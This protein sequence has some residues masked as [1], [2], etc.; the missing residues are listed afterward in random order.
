MP[1]LFVGH[2]SP[3]NAIEENE[4]SRG[5]R[6][7]AL[8]IPRPRAVLCVSAHWETPGLR[9]TAN[10][11]PD[12]IHDFQGFPERLFQARYPAPGS[13]GLAAR[14]AAL[15]SG[16]GARLD[17]RRGL[18]H[19]SWSVLSVMYPAADIPV[20]QLSLDSGRTVSSHLAT[21]RKLAP[22]RD[23]GVLV[24]GSGDIVHNLALIDFDRADG[25]DW[26]DRFNGAVKDRILAGDA[27]A[28]RD[29]RAIDRDADLAVPTPEHYLPLLYILALREKD[30]PLSCFNDKV[31]MGSI[32]MTSFGVGTAP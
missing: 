4:F 16:E 1:A 6:E 32:S 15:L 2:G 7:A 19:G 26:A 27:A 12:T 13:P 11:R 31:T 23:E 21:A 24:L 20:V 25:Y 29:W 5:W 8:R 30:E 18:D 3:L 17:G 22:L 9:L 28:V 14:A 10:E